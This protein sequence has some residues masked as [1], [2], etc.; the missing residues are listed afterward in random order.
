[1]RRI[2]LLTLAGLFAS[3]GAA[4][5]YFSPPLSAYSYYYGFTSQ[6]LHVHVTLVYGNKLTDID[7]NVN[8]P[9]SDG[10]SGAETY[11]WPS[12]KHPI[13]IKHG[14]FSGSTKDNIGA[15][16]TFTGKLKGKLI[17]GSFT[18]TDQRTSTEYCASGKVT[19]KVT[20]GPLKNW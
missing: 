4:L 20:R 13:P 11:D 5:A 9:C 15:A 19:F 3:G 17:T 18:L 10:H 6:H 2:A 14:N 1:M 8:A 12:S 7:Y 16:T